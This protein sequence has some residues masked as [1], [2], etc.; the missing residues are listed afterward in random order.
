MKI[1][2]TKF[3]LIALLLATSTQGISQTTIADTS[4][5]QSTKKLR[6]WSVGLNGGIL[7]HWTPFNRKTNGDYATPN[8]RFGYALF[9]KKQLLSDFGLQ[10]DFLFGK[11]NGSKLG[12]YPMGMAGQD[13]SGYE[14]KINWSADLRAYFTIPNLS[15]AIKSS[16]I[17][18]Y[19]TAGAG[20]MS[21]ST[22]VH[23]APGANSGDG[24]SWFL[25]LGI[26][27]KVGVSHA[28]NIDLGY[29]V[30]SVR[31]NNFDGYK[32]GL[33]DHFSYAYLG[34]EYS[35]GKKNTRPLQNYSTVAEVHQ[36]VK[37]INTELQTQ[38][39]I[40]EQKRLKDERDMADDDNDGVANKYDKCPGTPPNTPVDGAGC[41]LPVVKEVVKEKVVINQQDRRVIG[42]AIKNLEFVYGK[43]NIK[44]QSY[45][46]LNRVTDLLIQKDFSLK[47]AGHTDN[48]GTMAANLILSKARA[49]SVKAYLVAKGANASRI[50]ATGYGYTQPIATNKTAKGRRLNRRVEFTLF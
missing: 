48:R 18:P 43:A 23:N 7:T 25:P 4:K 46:T 45:E 1:T 36:E 40:A 31:T 20:Y 17:V 34:I 26:G 14:T 32:S 5:H 50:E 33:H 9:V 35:F 29:T 8:Q 47:L 39:A 19:L 42:D 38:T 41:P 13:Q 28:V 16:P 30:Y 12:N 3:C 21:Y 24:K 44:K 2:F 27:F 6:T 22:T 11:V 37:E 10:A 15:L 49:E